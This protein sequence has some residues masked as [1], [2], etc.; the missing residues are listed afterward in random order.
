MSNNFFGQRYNNFIDNQVK[1]NSLDE[2][3]SSPLYNKSKEDRESSDF[4]LQKMQLSL[5]N[6][7]SN[8]KKN[9]MDS[10]PNET[11]TINLEKSFNFN[12]NILAQKNLFDNYPVLNSRNEG[13]PRGKEKSESNLVRR[14][15]NAADL[16][17]NGYFRSPFNQDRKQKGFSAFSNSMYSFNSTKVNKTNKINKN[18]SLN[19]G[20][21]STSRSIKSNDIFNI[22]QNNNIVNNYNTYSYNANNNRKTNNNFNNIISQSNKILIN[23]NS[24]YSSEENNNK[25]N[26]IQENKNSKNNNT[27]LINNSIKA[28]KENLNSII[29][30]IDNDYKKIVQK[31]KEK[32]A[33]EQKLKEKEKNLPKINKNANNKNNINTNNNSGNYNKL[34]TSVQLN[35]LTEKKLK[36]MNDDI[37]LN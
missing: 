14:S 2:K 28:K 29:N 16:N 12:N 37:L 8:L 33:N 6:F 34:N 5:N 9:E 31:I 36:M 22:R 27:N 35:N 4:V 26:T 1:G 13:F 32:K 24:S 23:E 7:L 19:N 25:N 21:N 17:T 3:F 18:L 30:S 20:G 15:M 10:F 11:E